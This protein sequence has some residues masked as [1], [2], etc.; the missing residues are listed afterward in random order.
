MLLM[1]TEV[2][3]RSMQDTQMAGP[4]VTG[5]D[6]VVNGVT[7]VTTRGLMFWDMWNNTRGDVVAA[8]NLLPGGNFTC[9]IAPGDLPDTSLFQPGI[10]EFTLRNPTGSQYGSTQVTALVQIPRVPHLTVNVLGSA[11]RPI[12]S[13]G[14][15]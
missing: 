9:K 4:R 8:L 1:L 5:M 14:A 12:S 10:V 7:N 6:C 15:T 11:C 13:T 3:V 2:Y